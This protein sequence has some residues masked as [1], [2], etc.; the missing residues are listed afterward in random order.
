MIAIFPEIAGAVAA[1]EYEQLGVLVRKYF[2]EDE[3][4]KPQPD[5]ERLFRQVGIIVDTQDVP[6]DG[7]MVARDEKGRFDVMAILSQNLD[8][9]LKKRFL[10]AHQLGHY[11][12]HIQPLIARGDWRNS[13]FRETSCPMKRYELLVEN[14]NETEEDEKR[15]QDADRFAASLL[16]PRGMLLRARAKIEDPEVLASFFGVTKAVLTRRLEEVM[17]DETAAPQ[18]FLV[19]ERHLNGKRASDVL[20]PNQPKASTEELQAELQGKVPE[21]VTSPK[22]TPY[23]SQQ[24]KKDPES[25]EGGLSRLREIAQKIENKML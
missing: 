8:C 23:H 10:M 5:L 25:S 24:T 21:T 20:A 19:A 2:G 3:K 4:F 13:G 22:S 11:F 12:L 18:S 17:P 9:R 15:E 16:L 7:A 6:Y 14:V 1:Q